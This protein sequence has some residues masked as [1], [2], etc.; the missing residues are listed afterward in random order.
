MPTLVNDLTPLQRSWIFEAFGHYGEHDELSNGEA[1]SDLEA[2]YDI[3]NHDT[4]TP[5]RR[6]SNESIHNF[7]E[8][9]PPLFSNI[10]PF[11]ITNCH[12][13]P[14][15]PPVSADINRND[16][17]DNRSS[18]F[19]RSIGSTI[20]TTST[21]ID[22]G[23]RPSPTSIR[24]ERE[25][26]P[27]PGSIWSPLQD[28]KVVATTPPVEDHPLKSGNKRSSSPTG[29]TGRS[30]NDNNSSSKSFHM[31]PSPPFSRSINHHLNA[32]VSTSTLRIPTTT[33]TP[34][35]YH[36]MNENPH[37]HYP[38]PHPLLLSHPQQVP[39]H[40]FL[41]P[42]RPS[43]QYTNE[44]VVRSGNNTAPTE[45]IRSSHQNNGNRRSCETKAVVYPHSEEKLTWQ[46]SFE[47]L[48]IYKRIYGDCNVPQKYKMNVKLGGWVVCFFI[49]T[50]SF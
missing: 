33:I 43:Q 37:F 49:T 15:L 27:H 48:K 42:M 11:Q 38:Q 46:Q 8:P 1:S 16:L 12:D 36:P 50:R 35:R 18:I 28:R 34:T 10:H 21:T 7:P 22:D 19:R 45:Q 31:F 5:V 47:N 20:T 41:Y 2:H 40:P 39:V 32:A 3:H 30:P 44:P 24:N 23:S 26:Q 13:I 6:N 25:S 17:L 4:S 14:L 9:S 29:R